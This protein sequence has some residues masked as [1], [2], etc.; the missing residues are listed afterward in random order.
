M[1][2]E[3]EGAVARAKMATLEMHADARRLLAGRPK[4]WEP[5]T[6][7]ELVEA[8]EHHGPYVCTS[9][10]TTVCDFY[11]MSDP[12]SASVR[13]G[14]TSKPLPFT[15]ASEHAAFMVKAANA[16]EELLAGLREIDRCL[17]Y[18]QI[19]S[20]SKTI[21]DLLAKHGGAA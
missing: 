3:G 6:P 12:S 8:T 10:G 11:A 15:D 14:G 7:Y 16:H 19:F 1:S 13:N 17:G 5:T 2:G 9:W 20:A 4:K 21:A 18:G